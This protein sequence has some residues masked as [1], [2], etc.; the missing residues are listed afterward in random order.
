MK[1]NLK[2]VAIVLGT[3]GPDK[4]L[5]ELHGVHY[6]FSG[7]ESNLTEVDD[8]NSLITVKTDD[9]TVK[10]LLGEHTLEEILSAMQEYEEPVPEPVTPKGM[11]FTKG[12]V[13]P[14]PELKEQS[15]DNV[16]I[17]KKK[18]IE[19]VK[20]AELNITEDISAPKEKSKRPMSIQALFGS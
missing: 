11:A 6:T 4:V 3:E 17:V 9:E 18:E 15:L 2:V 13:N 8:I 20:E 5:F 10:K 7:K 16:D 12:N 19:K 1:N 14:E